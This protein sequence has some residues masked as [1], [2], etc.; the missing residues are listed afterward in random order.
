MKKVGE[1]LKV[2]RI[3][4]KLTLNDVSIDTKIQKKYLKAIEESKYS[5]LPAVTFVKGFIQ[6]YA[7]A[8][9]A[10]PKTMLA[11]FRRDFSQDASGQIV[12][13]SLSKPIEKKI[14]I[15]PKTTTTIIV[16]ITTLLITSLFARQIILFYKGPEI[17][18]DN[19][20]EE[21]TITS[22]FE[23]SGTASMEASVSVNNQTTLTNQSGEFTTQLQLDPGIHIITVTATDR[24]G[25]TTTTQRQ[26]NISP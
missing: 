8:I 12:P 11:I 2:A 15:S 26:V 6:N 21:Q 5:Q 14:S 20:R 13:R 25:K 10:N 17:S 18:I 23:V 7:K 3:N 22:P 4:K 19:P 16:T 9:N 24:D 1:L